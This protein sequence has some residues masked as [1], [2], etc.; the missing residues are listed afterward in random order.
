MLCVALALAFWGTGCGEDTEPGPAGDAASQPAAFSYDHEAGFCDDTD[1]GGTPYFPGRPLWSDVEAYGPHPQGQPPAP[2]LYGTPDDMSRYPS[3]EY[4]SANFT[5]D[6]TIQ[7]LISVLTNMTSKLEDA[8]ETL[9]GETIAEDLVDFGLNQSG[10]INSATG[11]CFCLN[12]GGGGSCDLQNVANGAQSAF[13]NAV[14]DFNADDLIDDLIDDLLD[15][16]VNSGDP[17][18]SGIGASIDAAQ[19]QVDVGAQLE[20][21]MDAWL[22]ANLPGCAA[23]LDTGG[24]FALEWQAAMQDLEAQLEADFQALVNA[25]DYLAT[26]LW[27]Q[28]KETYEDAKEIFQQATADGVSGLFQLDL[29]ELSE[30]INAIVDEWEPYIEDLEQMAEDLEQLWNDNLALYDRLENMIT[31]LQQELS[32]ATDQCA[33]ELANLDLNDPST[34]L[35]D[36]LETAATSWWNDLANEISPLLGLLSQQLGTGAG[37]INSFEGGLG[38][39][40]QLLLNG[41]IDECYG[42]MTR[43]ECSNKCGGTGEFVWTPDDFTQNPEAGLY[44]AADS[45]MFVLK[46]A[47]FLDKASEW[48][49]DNQ[50]VDNIANGIGQVLDFA[51]KVIE[52]LNEIAN[53]LSDVEQLVDRF[54]EGYHIGAYSDLRPDLHMCIGYAGHGAYAQFGNLGG[55][56]FSIGAR[57]TSHNLSAEHRVQFH[58]GGFAVSAFGHD[59]SLAPGVEFQTQIDG[60]RA[61]NTSAPFGIPANLSINQDL[62]GT[63][64]VF[65]VV[66]DDSYYADDLSNNGS[67]PVASFFIKDMFPVRPVPNTGSTPLWPRPNVDE[68]WEEFSSAVLSAGLNLN[69]EFPRSEESPFNKELAAIPLYGPLPQVMAYPRLT[70]RFGA[71]WIHDT[72]MMRQIAQDAVNENLPSASQLDA[73]DFNRDMHA[74]QAPDVSQDNKTEVYV[75]P[76]VG[77]GIGVGIDW[78]A[79]EIMI[80]FSIDLSVELR[81]GGGG[82]IVDLNAA[83]ADALVNSNPPADAPCE[84]V[85]QFNQATQCSN[86]LYSE[87]DALSCSPTSEV[88]QNGSCCILVVVREEPYRLCIDSFVAGGFELDRETCGYFNVEGQAPEIIEQLQGLPGW[89]SFI[90][91][92]L[93]DLITSF[94]SAATVT[95]SWGENT[96]IQRERE[97]KLCGDQFGDKVTDLYPYDSV[98]IDGGISASECE[99]HGACVNAESGEPTNTNA[100]GPEDCRQGERFEP[101]VCEP[102]VEAEL[103]G[104]EGD[105]CHPLQ[106]GFPSACGCAEDSD[107]ASGETCDAGQCTDGSQSFS[108]TCDSGGGCPSGRQCSDGACLLPCATDSDCAAGRVCDGGLCSPPH[109]IPTTESIVWGME[110]VEAPMH[111]ISSYAWSDF[112]FT[113]VLTLGFGIELGI[114]LGFFDLS[115]QILDLSEG[116]DLGSTYK[117]WYQPG[118]EALYQDECH[119]P[120]LSFPVT[121]RFPYSLTSPPANADFEPD[122]VN[123]ANSCGNGFGGNGV[124]RYCNPGPAYAESPEDY[125]LGNCGD[126]DAFLDWCINDMPQNQENPGATTPEDIVTGII[127]TGNFGANVGTEIW[128]ASQPC[129]NGQ[130]WNEWVQ[131]VGPQYDENGNIVG[132][133][134][135]DLDC[136]YTDPNNGQSYTFACEDTADAMMDIW[137]CS[138]QHNPWFGLVA[139]QY[140]SLVYGSPYQSGDTVID[141]TN[142]MQMNQNF[143]PVN[144]WSNDFSYALGNIAPGYLSPGTIHFV[145]FMQQCMRD[146][147]GDPA[148]LTCECTS[149]DECGVNGR[150]DNG[151]CEVLRTTDEQG[152]CYTQDCSPVWTDK[153]CSPVSLV[154]VEVG[155][156]CG[157]GVVQETDTYSEDCD[158]MDPS[159]PACSSTCELMPTYGACCG[160]DGQC[161]EALTEEE[162]ADFGGS[163]TEGADCAALD[164][165]GGGGAD[166][167]GAC[168]GPDGCFDGVSAQECAASTGTFYAGESCTSID[169][170]GGDNFNGACCTATGCQEGISLWECESRYD[171]LFTP[172]A[173]CEA[174]GYCDDEERGSC[175]ANGSCF[176][177]YTASQCEGAV[178]NFNAGLSCQEVNYCGDG[179]DDQRGACCRPD[180][181]CE[182]M[183]QVFCDASDGTWNAGAM[184]SEVTCEP[185]VEEGSCCLRGS[186]YE[187]LDLE[188]CTVN[189]GNWFPDT[190]CV[191]LECEEVELGACC[192]DEGCLDSVTAERCEVYGGQFTATLSCDEVTCDNEPAY[193]ACCADDQCNE[194]ISETH[195]DVIGGT[196]TPDTMCAAIECGE[197]PVIGACCTEEG[198]FDSVEE[199]KCE[200]EMAGTFHVAQACGQ[201]E[202]QPDEPEWGACCTGDS[203]F[204]T[205]EDRCLSV[206]G[207]FTGGA[208]CDEV[209]CGEAT[210]NCCVD[211]DCMEDVLERSCD[212]LG[213]RWTEGA[214]C[215]PRSCIFAADVGVM[216]I[217]LAEPVPSGGCTATGSR[218]TPWGIPA[219]LALL[220][221]GLMVVRRRNRSAR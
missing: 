182:E 79:L 99:T 154:D 203:C 122:D 73:S 161:L 194:S 141:I 84:P 100:V 54:T 134:F 40:A 128:E 175:C 62:F 129:I 133:G 181:T 124:C 1:S 11:E 52:I 117:G 120:S 4:L 119:D 76:G 9:S 130:P 15:G 217:G 78:W 204:Q 170:C 164:Y 85:W 8:Q 113:S 107:C 31:T 195:C 165:C 35:V 51:Q 180:G 2:G 6:N 82:G 94:Q 101:Y 125:A 214:V 21:A 186:C 185:P 200:E 116:F 27:P 155:M 121:N 207:T 211:G 46:Q 7:F 188:K 136:G 45:G 179:G 118:L 44:V 19:L 87:E 95:S 131:G 157:D 112:L 126:V 206:G 16:L 20:A 187:D 41:A 147:D 208:S 220:A 42:V 23:G 159:G 111:Q 13:D 172:G 26:T 58:S 152:N 5:I 114:D 66:P 30:D 174:V 196:F 75:E 190:M 197:P 178:G 150:C 61:W 22:Q 103:T 212:R 65:N 29:D 49:A 48:L 210:G 3:Y 153:L 213:G 98:F 135:G 56:N 221:G 106:H 191:D 123:P 171:G 108:C 109:G 81:P 57:Y 60:W 33:D 12:I 53:I 205:I 148:E 163:F 156:C 32:G 137:E 218:Q 86:T 69:L 17:L 91:N 90:T 160:G 166:Q 96:C 25:W 102:R 18:V 104:W 72:N 47:G 216:D 115:W 158:P 63:M 43:L 110:N 209:Q 55:D 138:D 127:D 50:L 215:G 77:L 68:E 173:S 39:I 74:F 83:L 168:C 89:L 140:P 92:P 10:S 183:L 149:D 192:T 145:V 201:F 88:A 14:N 193:G 167:P 70:L 144:G 93:V 24:A 151:A 162:C 28:V 169:Q 38:D 146:R 184:C 219:G 189:G 36:A 97:G 59:L 143:D 67:V 37:S 176:N 64:D 80:R 142:M 202:C 34:T 198:C 139:S 132:G 105:G 71:D 177:D 199:S